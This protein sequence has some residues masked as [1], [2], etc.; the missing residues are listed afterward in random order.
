LRRRNENQ[1]GDG[2]RSLHGAYDS[3]L[4][5]SAAVCVLCVKD[6][7]SAENAEG[8]RDRRGTSTKLSG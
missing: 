8:R 4:R 7:F 5:I 2:K 6:G 1:Y 3:T